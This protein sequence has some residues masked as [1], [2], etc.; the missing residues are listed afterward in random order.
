MTYSSR[1]SAF[2]DKVIEA[3]WIAALVLVPLF[4]NVYSSRVF[5][6][7]KLTLLRSIALVM[8]GAW[9][10]KLIEERKSGRSLTG[11][12]NWRTPLV[13]PTL[14]LVVVYLVSSVL[15]IVPR[16]SFMG[17]YQR[18]QG[19]YTTLSYIV[20]FFM[21][22][23]NMRRREQLDRLVTA[24][25]M[26]SLPIAFY[27][28]LQHG[29]GTQSI[30]PLPWGGD[31][32]SR[33]AANMG[34]AI[35]VA[36]YLIM[37]FFLTLGRIVESFRVILTEKESRLSDILRAS[38]YVFIGAVQ[39]IAF[40]F[41]DSRGP[42]LGW[43]PG[44]FI[45]G[46]V[47]LLLLRVA[48]YNQ[49]PDTAGDAEVRFPIR[50]FDVLKALVMAGV[51]AV[52]AGAAAALA[53]GLFPV[54]KISLVV[55]AA[56]LGGL[57]PLLIVVGIRRTAARWLWA[58]WISFSIIGAVGLFLVNFSDMPLIV[59]LRQSGSFGRLSAL[60]E[61]EGGTGEVRSLIWEGA[62]KLV[63]P[64]APLTFPD[65]TTDSLNAIRP[66]IGYGPESM[67]VAYNPFYPPDLA[68]LEARNASP[69]RSHNEVWDS[70]VITG[71]IGF[72]AEQFLFLSV[73][74][75]ALKFIGWI[76]NRRAAYLLIGMM[77]A[78]GIAGSILLSL[79]IAPNFIGPGWTGGVTAGLVLYV[80]AFALFHFRIATRVYML[81]AAILIGLLD[82]AI[83]G[84]TFTSPNR[85]VEMTAATLVGV[86][87]F[88]LLYF[89]GRAVFDRT[90]NQPVQ[91]SGHIFLIVALFGGMLAHYLEIGLA[92]IAI[93]ATR[94][95]FWSYAALLVI[96]GLNWVLADEEPAQPKPAPAPAPVAAPKE[97]AANVPR[98]KKKQ[99]ARP[100]VAAST[101]RESR[102]QG[103]PGWVWPVL[104]M[105][106]I[107]AMILMTLGYEFINNS[108][109]STTPV[110]DATVLIINS[111]TRLPY[112]NNRESL[113]ALLMF[114]VTWIF[115]GLLSLTE[116]RRR[117]ILAAKDVLP[118]AA[119]Y[120]GASIVLALIYWQ[121]QAT[122]L[123]GL[124]TLLQQS[125]ITTLD[126]Y[127]NRVNE[128]LS[129]ANAVANL[130]TMFYLINL[131]LI[132]GMA[133]VLVVAEGRWRG[134]LAGDWGAAAAV[135]VIVALL[136]LI[137]TT[138]LNQI[139]A[140]TIYKQAEPLRAQGQW[141][142]AI[143]HYKRVIDLAPDEDF[144]YLWL[145]AAYLE[146]A[147]QAQEGPAIFSPTT[148]LSDMLRLNFQDTYRL[149]RADTLT[150]AEAVLL[151]ARALNPLNTDH[152]ANL[153]RLYRRWADLYASDPAVRQAKLAQSD[154]QYQIATTLSPNNAVLWNEW[155]TVLAAEADTARQ[156]GDTAKADQLL[157]EAQARLDHSFQLDQEFEQTY[158]IKAQLAR[159]QGQNDEARS[160]YQQ[161][162][163]RNPASSDAWTGLAD[164]L[165]AQGDYTDV[166]TVTLNFLQHNPNYLPALRTLAR[167]V[168]FP[169]NR[170]QE[171]IAMQ[172][173]VVQVGASDPNVWDDHRVLAILLAQTGQLTQA[174]QE[175][176]TALS[177]AP[178]DRHNEVQSL[179]DQIQAQLGL[180][181]PNTG[182]LPFS[183]P[184]APTPAP[185]P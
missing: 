109:Q 47:G 135:P 157:Q 85:V 178:A 80:I 163:E 51:S 62:L 76:P 59:Q 40:G 116:L 38:S 57:L 113:G 91:M 53:Y 49:S 71:G 20:V 139:R 114:A 24:V 173:Q 43:L 29:D 102:G 11:G 97:P 134:A 183:T 69:D 35:F 120:Y 34:N 2:C 123:L 154:Q 101:R 10:I 164:L 127:A 156:A 177:K 150:A 124:G 36:A 119:L 8:V 162:L 159:S 46:L 169:E 136:V 5:E 95:Y 121:L 182:T 168:Y 26:T 7:D 147:S 68:H 118:A 93:A 14:I 9:L 104:A 12:V 110:T 48:L 87:L 27:G 73:F 67:Y 137:P 4:F 18:L 112:Q 50:A 75:L 153:A 19:T 98:H 105:T 145:G 132:L 23:M 184:P 151:R 130:L 174:L 79:V 78:G 37:A 88:A 144:Y 60:F 70:F 17:S 72:V 176:Q 171:A 185:A 44:M 45:F 166:E 155:A 117:N 129:L 160:I 106:L 172:Q 56:L 15:S 6:P 126:Q 131:L 13:L 180:S 89:V 152:S 41:A 30:D 108:P 92:G 32:T 138:N 58:S 33:V 100:A 165:V 39:L 52:G 82:L 161:A 66:L 141:D 77:V 64:H 99:A 115:G 25:V 63:L 175:A 128:L 16:V 142:V 83:F 149:S 61:T 81:I 94:T 122:Q 179:V 3:G 42:L 170:L 90:A 107:G 111:L 167:N 146:K 1:L 140:D 22:L 65:G 181:T 158:L 148:Q 96:T 143:A 31:V 54:T 28:L 103:L 21:L 55:V 74:F 133:A 86:A 125:Q 84:S